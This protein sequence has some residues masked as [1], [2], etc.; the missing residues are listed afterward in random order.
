MLIYTRHPQ[1]R[2]F[3]SQR[4][5]VSAIYPRKERDIFVT[6]MGCIWDIVEHMSFLCARVMSTGKSCW[7]TKAEFSVKR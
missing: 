4:N 7:E 1:I 2:T 3:Q 6:I 5:P